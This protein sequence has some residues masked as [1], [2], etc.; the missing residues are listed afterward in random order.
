MSRPR[1]DVQFCALC[2]TARRYGS[3]PTWDLLG[4]DYTQQFPPDT[5]FPRV[6]PRLDLFVRFLV[7]GGGPAGIAVR[8]WW[9]YP[10]GM[11]RERVL[12]RPFSVMLDPT[13]PVREDVFRLVNIPVPGEGLYAVRVC[14]RVRH[15]WKGL[16]WRV[17]KSEFFQ[18]VR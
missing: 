5:E 11:D 13:A 2:R 10:N 18:V 15:R 12:H 8:V 14:R 6:I 9:L 17:M 16:R 1:L 7:A 4:L 3:H